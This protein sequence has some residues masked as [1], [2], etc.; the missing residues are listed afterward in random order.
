M[1]HNSCVGGSEIAKM[2]RHLYL[3]RR[4]SL[5]RTSYRFRPPLI[6]LLGE[7][8]EHTVRQMRQQLFMREVA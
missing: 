8:I 1:F 6:R 5:T 7:L 3:T 2:N 4:R